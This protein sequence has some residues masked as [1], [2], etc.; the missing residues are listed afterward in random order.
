[1]LPPDALVH[2]VHHVYNAN[3]KSGHNLV[4]MTHKSLS[5]N[6]SRGFDYSGS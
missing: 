2:P 6:A 1:M 4:T 5:H 3:E